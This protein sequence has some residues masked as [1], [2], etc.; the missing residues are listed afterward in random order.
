M[1]CPLRNTQTQYPDETV[2]IDAWD[3]LKEEC[4]WWQKD[5][6][7]GKLLSQGARRKKAP[8]KS[9]L[10][11][12]YEWDK[13]NEDMVPDYPHLE[14]IIWNLSKIQPADLYR[15]LGVTSRTDL[16]IPAWE[17]FLTLKAILHPVNHPG[18]EE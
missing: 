3:C 11:P 7:K 5:A 17:A 8:T 12:L 1:K 18:E 4:A 9:E 13:I 6:G 14:P 2:G 16:T 15:E 10:K